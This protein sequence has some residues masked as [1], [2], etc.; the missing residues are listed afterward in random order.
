MIVR[1]LAAIALVLAAFDVPPPWLDRPGLALV[2]L[3]FAAL[4]LP[5]RL[6][7]RRPPLLPPAA[8]GSQSLAS[9]FPEHAHAGVTGFDGDGEADE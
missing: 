4:A 7:I 2:G 8:G 6:R 9:M 1:S 5:G 3:A